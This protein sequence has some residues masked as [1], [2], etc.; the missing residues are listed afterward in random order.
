MFFHFLYIYIKNTNRPQKRNAHQNLKLLTTLW[1]ID[2]QQQYTIEHSL[3]LH[4][5]NVALFD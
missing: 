3:C 5:N 2:L 4:H 1:K